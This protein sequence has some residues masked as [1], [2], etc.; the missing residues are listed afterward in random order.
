MKQNNAGLKFY[1][2]EPALWCIRI[3]ETKAD[4]SIN[5]HDARHT[6]RPHLPQLSRSAPA[7][8][9]SLSNS[10]SSTCTCCRA[11]SS[12]TMRPPREYSAGMSA[13]AGN[14]ERRTAYSAGRTP[15]SGDERC[16]ASRALRV[17]RGPSRFSER[18][19]FQCPLLLRS[20]L[21]PVD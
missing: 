17:R 7:V 10:A 16:I 14:S 11:C 21:F 9:S 15:S 2:N 5:L 19:T 1:G 8:R 18:Q 20:S 13:V 4:I 3:V 6:V 12:T